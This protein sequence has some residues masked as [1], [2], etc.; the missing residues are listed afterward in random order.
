[1]QAA[2]VPREL[3]R[4]VGLE[5]VG[6]HGRGDH[7]DPGLSRHRSQPVEVALGIA[8]VTIDLVTR[9][10]LGRDAGTEVV[11][12]GVELDVELLAEPLGPHETDEAPW[13]D[14]IGDHTKAQRRSSLTDNVSTGMALNV[15]I[16]L[17]AY[18]PGFHTWR[19]I[20]FVSSSR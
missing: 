12:P 9:Q 3:C 17:V 18:G 16:A 20:A 11:G 13:S 2:T 6:H 1:M 14:V 19:I 15:G 7:L 5:G 8:T 10:A 4:F